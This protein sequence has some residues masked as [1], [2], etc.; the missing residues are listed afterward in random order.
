MG[1]YTCTNPNTNPPTCS[2]PNAIGLHLILLNRSFLTDMNIAT[3]PVPTH[4]I[5]P[6]QLQPPVTVTVTK[7]ASTSHTSSR[8][9]GRLIPSGFHYFGFLLLICYMHAAS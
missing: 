2:P 5:A 6:S 4:T 9:S 8:A 7:A 3:T 1:G